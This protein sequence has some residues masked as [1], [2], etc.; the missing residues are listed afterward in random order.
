MM[1]TGA[2]M[3][4]PCAWQNWGHR[5]SSARFGPAWHDGNSGETDFLDDQ[6]APIGDRC[7]EDEGDRKNPAAVARDGVG[8]DQWSL[9]VARL[10][11]G[12]VGGSVFGRLLEL[13]EAAANPGRPE[14]RSAD[15]E[16]EVVSPL[17]FATWLQP[18]PISWRC[19][20][21]TR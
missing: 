9:A 13:D 6:S 3:R 1:M 8:G 17:D 19:P 7:G 12:D 20:A 11:K 18:A 5:A 4:A 2:R 16:V 21:K 14:F 15:L 10:P